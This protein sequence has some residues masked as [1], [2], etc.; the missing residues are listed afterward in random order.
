MELLEQTQLA[1]V[2]QQR[3]LVE[4]ALSRRHVEHRERAAVLGVHVVNDDV[5]PPGAIKRV[6]LSANPS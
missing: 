2:R 5:S 4:R 3:H 1:G 6:V